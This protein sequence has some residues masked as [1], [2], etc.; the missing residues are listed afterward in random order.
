MTRRRG[1]IIIEVAISAG[2]LGVVFV[3]VSHLLG[4][5]AHRQRIAEARREATQEAANALERALLIPFDELAPARLAEISLDDREEGWL[6]DPKLTWSVEMLEG[7][8]PTKRLTAEVVWFTGNAAP[9]R[10]LLSAWQVQ[11]RAAP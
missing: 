7:S 8:P 11:E 4:V 10:V 9:Q 5:V 3:A 6:R 2:L 1:G